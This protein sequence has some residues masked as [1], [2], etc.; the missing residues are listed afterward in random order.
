MRWIRLSVRSVSH[1][2]APDKPHLVLVDLEILGEVLVL[3]G[4]VDLGLQLV[5]G[6]PGGGGGGPVTGGVVRVVLDMLLGLDPLIL[7]LN[8]REKLIKYHGN[9]VRTFPL[10]SQFRS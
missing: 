8:T 7:H 10:L 2:V 6:G 4:L 3:P 5:S 1:S 9:R